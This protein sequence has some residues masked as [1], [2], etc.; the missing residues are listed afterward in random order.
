MDS[1]TNDLIRAAEILSTPICKTSSWAIQQNG[2]VTLARDMLSPQERVA[3]AAMLWSR[4]DDLPD[5][6]MQLALIAWAFPQRRE[7]LIPQLETL[8]PNARAGI[9]IAHWLGVPRTSIRASADYRGISYRQT[10]R[11][12]AAVCRWMT[13]AFEGGLALVEGA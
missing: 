9:C 12:R 4:V 3:G 11:A 1:I 10:I 5:P 13:D 7:W 8:A 2:K 6:A